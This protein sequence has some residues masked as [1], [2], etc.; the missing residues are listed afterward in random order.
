MQFD[1][2]AAKLLEP[3]QHFTISDCP[4]LRLEA[5]AS[6]RSWVYRFKSP[7]DDRMRQVKIGTWPKMSLVAA[8]VEWEKLREIR[9][10]GRDPA[11][12]RRAT[13]K[14][15]READDAARAAASR[16]LT[17]RKLCDLYLEGQVVRN[18]KPKS[19]AETRRTFEKMLGDFGDLDP[20][21]VTRAQAF[22]LIAAYIDTPVQAARLRAEL[23]AAWDYGLDAGRLDSNIPNWWRLIMRG[24]LRSKGRVR[25]GESIGPAKRVLSAEEVG[26]LIR[27]LPN[28]SR[29]VDDVVTLYMWTCT[30]GSEILSMEVNE[31]THESDGLWWTVPKDKTKNSWRDHAGDLRVPLVG[32]AEAVVRRRME[33]V[34]SGFLF[35]S[36]GK[37]GHV[38]Q[39]TVSAMV[40]MHQPYSKT[41][42]EYTRARLPVSHWSVHDL[43]RTGRTQ[44]AAMGCRDE[45]AEAVLGHM[46]AG[47][48]G[49]YNLHRYD[50]ERREWLR[51]LSDHYENLAKVNNAI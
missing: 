24:K 6:T 32:R 16:R 29:L 44:L 39:K 35:P 30:R 36:N 33:L 50:A 43:R 41:R 22:D 51:R 17:V 7:I 37:S 26:T 1:A 34:K 2:K 18:R 9:S 40:W 49:I 38:E 21:A 47:I 11:E 3:G 12:E 19:A 31:I 5:S 42:P 46:P 13:R 14:S 25:E 27:W 28:F 8:M 45:I 48:V 10:A 23:G 15:E 4:G 20:A